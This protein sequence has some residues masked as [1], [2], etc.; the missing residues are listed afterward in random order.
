M[1]KD[2]DAILGSSQDLFRAQTAAAAAC[3]T[4]SDK[5][6]GDSESLFAR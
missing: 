2:L 6:L 5:L 3:A 1:K 4:G